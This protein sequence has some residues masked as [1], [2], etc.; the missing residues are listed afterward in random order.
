M[1]LDFK[2]AEPIT[3]QGSWSQADEEDF[4]Y[5]VALGDLIMEIGSANFSTNWGWIP[6]IDVAVSL[7]RIADKLQRHGQMQ[8]FEFT[9]S[10][11]WLRIRRQEDDVIVTASYAP[12]NAR[13]EYSSFIDAI[14]H[15]QKQLRREL[16]RLNPALS[17]NPDFQRLLPER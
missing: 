8:T 10:E 13:V 6:L 1:K 17:R 15:L 5:R 4:R 14:Q 11:S 3:D 12:G 9:E 7:Q 2:L 16:L